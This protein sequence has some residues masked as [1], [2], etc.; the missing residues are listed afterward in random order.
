MH[1]YLLLVVS[2]LLAAATV[3]QP[4]GKVK[5]PQELAWL[6][7]KATFKFNDRWSANMDVQ[8]RIFI[9]PVA[10]HQ[11]VIRPTVTRTLG[12]GWDLG[13]GFCLFLQSPHDPRSTSDLVVPELRPHLEINAK[14][15]VRYFRIVQRFKAEARYFHEVEDGALAGG[16]AF[17]NFR[18]RYRAGLDVPLVKTGANS[19]EQLGLS[20]SNELMLNAGSR[21]TY[22]VFDQNR[23]YL[24][25]YTAVSPGLTVELG[26]LNW[27]QQRPSGVDFYDRHIVRLGINQKFGGGKKATRGT[28]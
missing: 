11:A 28:G 6:A 14:Q 19:R 20:I 15:H 16:F 9:N 7:Y 1:R 4:T 18:L 22:N 26:Y 13:A 8:D 21:I 23:V 2:G 25:L 24:G 10:Q 5:T 3:A 12:P 17:S 27:Y